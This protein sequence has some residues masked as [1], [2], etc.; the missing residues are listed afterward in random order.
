MKIV[1]PD[2]I[3]LDKKST[4]ELKNLP[5]I[6]VYEDLP[7]DT[8]ALIERIKD[9]E[10]VTA[11]FV[12]LTKKVIEAAPRLKYIISPAV[13]YDWIDAETATQHGIKILNC[14]TFNSQAVA[15][16]AIALMFA[17]KRKIV[18]A[19]ISMLNKKI[20]P[21]EFVGSEVSGKTLTTFGHGHIGK[22]IIEIAN[23]LGMKT[24]FIDTQT[25]EEM[26]KQIIS[27]T[28]VLVL[29]LPLN[30]HT[31]GIMSAERIA[32]MKPDAILINVARGLVVDQ[33][34][35]YETLSE[36]KIVGAGIDTYPKDETV[37]ETTEDINRFVQLLNVVSTPHIG[38]NTKEALE[39]LGPEII[40]N[41][42]SCIDGRPVNVVN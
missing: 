5:N 33:A 38:F 16:H 17:V 42:Q 35:L 32:L 41:I 22:K 12:D 31:T 29:C 25:P 7:Q 26:I 2:K 1:I 10:I 15:E 36:G 9:A 14:P 13:G 6:T 30:K 21:K 28:D 23:G 24:Q 39:R 18:R 4:D 8:A 27:G 11:N 20:A 37:K 19:N 34:A 3:E 40:K